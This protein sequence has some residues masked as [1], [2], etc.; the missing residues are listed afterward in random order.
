[1]KQASL[2]DSP[3]RNGLTNVVEREPQPVGEP[4]SSVDMQASLESF[5][6]R[7][8]T[9][10]WL[11]MLGLPPALRGPKSQNAAVDRLESKG[12]T[13]QRRNVAWRIWS[14]VFCR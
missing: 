2:K 4:C 14:P 1:M 5:V 13:S 10:V 3:E 12:E 9:D 7:G 8:G 6:F 11:D